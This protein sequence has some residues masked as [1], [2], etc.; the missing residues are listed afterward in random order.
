MTGIGL[1]T[2]RN[3]RM[4]RKGPPYVKLDKSVRYLESDVLAY[5]ESRRVVPD[6]NGKCG[7]CHSSGA[8]R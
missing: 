8:Q 6:G 5:M 1:Q 3:Y 4:L 7:K 2:L